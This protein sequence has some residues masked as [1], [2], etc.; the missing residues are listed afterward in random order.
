MKDKL[1]RVIYISLFWCT[2]NNPVFKGISLRQSVVNEESISI[3]S[4]AQHSRQT[5]SNDFHIAILKSSLGFH[6]LPLS[7]TKIYLVG[8]TW[9]LSM[10]VLDI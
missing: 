10:L 6:V 3:T 9:F 2:Y 5:L 1:L 8:F 7:P 4:V